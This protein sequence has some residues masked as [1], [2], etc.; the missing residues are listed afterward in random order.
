MAETNTPQPNVKEEEL[1]LLALTKRLWE[2]RKFILWVTGCF[3]VLGVLVALITPVSF[4][5]TYTFVPQTSTKTTGGGLSSLAAMAGISL[6]GSMSSGEVLS[7]MVYPQIMNNFA[8]K[9][10]LMNTPI[11]FEKWDQPV[12]LL[13]Y[14]TDPELL[15]GKFWG[16][17][18]NYTIGLPFTILAAVRGEPDSVAVAVPTNEGAQPLIISYEEYDCLQKLDKQVSMSLNEKQGYITLSASMPDAYAAYQVANRTFELLQQYITAFKIEKVQSDYDFIK[19]RHDEAKRVMDEKRIAYAQFK[20]AN[21]ILSSTM[22]SVKEEELQSDYELA[23][24]LYTELATQMLQA[25]I[26]VKEDTP[27]LTA[28]QPAVV[29]YMRTKPARAKMVVIYTFLGG[30]LAC[31]A[32]FGIDYLKK[33]AGM[34]KPAKW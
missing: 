21:R 8:F 25:G 3:M 18:F 22:A 10:D 7:P 31:G 24:A 5:S 33:N 34:K 28:I 11:K 26:K 16:A 12:T 13:D 19:A 20:D 30:I 27:V 6:G 17:V 4:T 23:Q 15:D 9:R 1:D 2:K 32:V 29:P 14:Y